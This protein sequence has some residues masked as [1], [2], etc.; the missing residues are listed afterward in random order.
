MG[1]IRRRGF[2]ITSWK[3]DPHT[4]RHVHVATDKNKF[5][6]RITHD[7]QPLENWVPSRKLREVIDELKSE[8]LL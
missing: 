1:R 5:L 8:G 3:G 4:P 6:G 2:I 7:K